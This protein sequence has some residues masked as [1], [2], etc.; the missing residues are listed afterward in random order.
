[1]TR[2]AYSRVLTGGLVAVALAG[3]GCSS[4]PLDGTWST[5]FTVL[6]FTGT[7]T[8]DVSSDG[9]LK[10]TVTSASASCS[11]TEVTTGYQWAATASSITFSGTPACTGSITCGA[12]SLD[13]SKSGSSFTAGSCTYTLSDSN[14][15]LALTACSGT[16]DATYIRAD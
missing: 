12:L 1:M 2:Q 13:C 7:E 15:T 8:I 3:T 5:A 9:T 16:S 14:D 10:V 11:G 6:T 4:N